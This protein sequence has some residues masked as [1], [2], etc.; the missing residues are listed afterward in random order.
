MNITRC[1][2]ARALMFVCNGR[3][4]GAP[5]KIAECAAAATANQADCS[6]MCQVNFHVVRRKLTK[7]C[8]VFVFYSAKFRLGP[9]VYLWFSSHLLGSPEG[10]LPL[11]SLRGWIRRVRRVVALIRV[12]VGNLML[13]K[14]YCSGLS[15]VSCRGIWNRNLVCSGPES[16]CVPVGLFTNSELFKTAVCAA[17]ANAVSKW[18]I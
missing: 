15:C 17:T 9:S 5:K 7:K 11:R 10:L 4:L 13:N 16:T 2:I 12:C 3:L 18:R 8:C 1:K 6:L 14:G